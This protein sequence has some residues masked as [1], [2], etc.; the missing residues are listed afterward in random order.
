MEFES[1]EQAVSMLNLDK[2]RNW[3][4]FNGK[5][6]YGSKCTIPCSG[7]SCDCSDGYGCSHSNSGCHECGYTGKRR[8]Y[9]PVFY[10]TSNEELVVIRE[11]NS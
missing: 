7:C 3:G 9:F 1:V 6:C 11:E 2:R 4:T 10:V 8:S 5:L